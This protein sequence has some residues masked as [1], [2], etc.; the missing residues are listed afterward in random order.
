MSDMRLSC[1]DETNRIRMVSCCFDNTGFG[2]LRHDKTDAY[3]TLSLIDRNV[4]HVA[5][6]NVLSSRSNQLVVG[7]L[8]E[9]VCSPA[10]DA[11]DCEYWRVEIQRDAHHVIR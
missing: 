1:R 9:D 2:W 5:R 11:T 6:P 10:S 8:L 7:I 3:R 4:R